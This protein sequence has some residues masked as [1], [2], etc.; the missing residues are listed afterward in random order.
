M[1]DYNQLGS[2]GQGG[3]NINPKDLPWVGCSEGVQ[4]YEQVFL[5]KRLSPIISPT[6]KEE[7]VPAE[8]IICKKC[9]KVPQFISDK[10][11]DIPVEYRS[12]CGPRKA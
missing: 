3:L 7:M 1:E 9:G 4:V 5:F 12:T 2:P 8:V 6:G 10:I 11:P